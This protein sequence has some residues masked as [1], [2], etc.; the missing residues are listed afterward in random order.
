MSAADD[1]AFEEIVSN[2]DLQNVIYVKKDENQIASVWA[3]GSEL[4]FF[5]NVLEETAANMAPEYPNHFYFFAELS[6]EG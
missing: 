2:E 4:S 5:S 3:V 1:A 6:T